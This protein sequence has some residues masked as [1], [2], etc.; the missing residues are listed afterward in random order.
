MSRLSRFALAAALMVA[1]V[2]AFGFHQQS[3]AE[4]NQF[5]GLSTQKVMDWCAPTPDMPQAVLDCRNLINYVRLIPSGTVIFQEQFPQQ[6]SGQVTFDVPAVTWAIDAKSQTGESP[7]FVGFLY[8]D[9]EG[10]LVK[11]L[12]PATITPKCSGMTGFDVQF[13]LGP[14]MGELNTPPAQP[15][16]GCPAFENLSQLVG[17]DQNSWGIVRDGFEYT[18]NMQILHIPYNV[19]A[20]SPEE[21]SFSLEGTYT[22][23][24]HEILWCP[25]PA[26]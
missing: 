7:F 10:K 1:F 25:P 23:A 18:G 21:D 5:L 3:S 13:F 6:C 15:V 8:H 12:G 22:W 16:I 9:H 2:A 24:T 20:Q 4:D 11:G 17:G 26:A 14:R 19:I